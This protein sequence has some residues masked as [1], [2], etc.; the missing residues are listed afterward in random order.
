[1]YI[2]DI[3]LE[4]HNPWCGEWLAISEF[5]HDHKMRKIAKDEFL[6]TRRLF[7]HAKWIRHMYVCHVLDH[8]DRQVRPVS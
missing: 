3:A 7:K 5:N 8:P 4:R 6:V 2:D 1:M